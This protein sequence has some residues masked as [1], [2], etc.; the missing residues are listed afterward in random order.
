VLSLQAIRPR[1]SVP[2]APVVAFDRTAD[3]YPVKPDWPHQD[4]RGR[5]KK[6]KSVFSDNLPLL[7][8]VAVFDC[9]VDDAQSIAKG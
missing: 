8:I 7:L 2:Y 4:T 9:A 5:A 3:L 6:V 1:R